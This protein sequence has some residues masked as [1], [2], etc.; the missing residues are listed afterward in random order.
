MKV[1]ITKISPLLGYIEYIQNGDKVHQN[2]DRDV[3]YLTKGGL[4]IEMELG[5]S[6]PLNGYTGRNV[7]IE[8]GVHYIIIAEV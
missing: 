3:L 1:E 6:L 8:K 5:E 7:K 4:S 2:I